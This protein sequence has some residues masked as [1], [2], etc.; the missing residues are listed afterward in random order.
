MNKSNLRRSALAAALCCCVPWCTTA[1]HAQTASA[2]SASM[3]KNGNAATRGTSALTSTDV[4]FLRQAAENGHAEVQ[5]SKVALAKTA[6][7]KVKAFAQQM[8][9]DHTKAGD[10]L[11]A[12]A[13]SKGVDV[14]TKP[15]VAQQAKI[16]LTQ[17]L[18]GASYD[19]RYAQTFG[20]AAHEDTVKLFRK[21]ATSARDADVK[22]FASKTLPTLEHHLSMAKDLKTSTAAEKTASSVN[23]RPQ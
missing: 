7:P 2:P 8:I 20:V 14:P 17:A 4:G 12:L 10:E 15:S 1:A 23:N 22:A 19:R 18:D 11:H 5:S 13:A 16:K 9:D 6:D 21:A 3:A